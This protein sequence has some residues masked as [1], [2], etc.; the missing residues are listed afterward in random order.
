MFQYKCLNPIS[1]CGTSLFTEEYKQ[2]EELQEADAVLVR[3]A[4]MH[5]MQD[6]PNLLAVARAGAGVNNIPIADYSDKGIVVFNTPGANANGVKEMVI[7]GMLLT[8]EEFETAFK[9]AVDSNEPY[10]LDCIIDSDDKVWPMVAPGGSIS[11]A[12]N[13][14]DLEKKKSELK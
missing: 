8:I 7:A 1:A 5:D 2:V 6:V 12:F 9:E 4:A 14:E 10:V 3:S 13:E 11:D